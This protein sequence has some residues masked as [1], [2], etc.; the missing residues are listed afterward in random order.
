MTTSPDF[1]GWLP[2]LITTTGTSSTGKL[3]TLSVS[4]ASCAA[5]DAVCS[6]PSDVDGN[7]ITQ[8]TPAAAAAA[9]GVLGLLP[10]AALSGA[11]GVAVS[12]GGVMGNGITVLNAGAAGSV[13]LGA[14]GRAARATRPNGAEFRIGTV[15]TAGN[16]TIATAA[17]RATSPVHVYNI[18][19]YGGVPDADTSYGMLIGSAGL[20]PATDCLPAFNAAKAAIIA[21][22]A[23]G[24]IRI[25]AAPVG[26]G[27]FFSDVLLIDTVFPIE[28]EGEAAFGVTGLPASVCIFAAGTGGIAIGAAASGSIV[29]HLTCC[30]PQANAPSTWHALASIDINKC[31]SPA[32]GTSEVYY[33]GIATVGPYPFT[34]STQPVFPTCWESAI[35]FPVGGEIYVTTIAE[36]PGTVYAAPTLSIPLSINAL[37]TTYGAPWRYRCTVEGVTAE[38]RFAHPYSGPAPKWT[39]GVS[40]AANTIV[41]PTDGAWTGA[42]FRVTTPGTAG[43][44][45]NWALA[46]GPGQTVTSGSVTYTWLATCWPRTAGLTTVDGT[47]SWVLDDTSGQFIDG[48][49]TWNVKPCA[50]AIAFRMSAQAHWE[51]LYVFNWVGD[52]YVIDGSH[53]LG[54]QANCWSAYRPHCTNVMGD[55]WRVAG[56]DCG[57]GH[58]DMLVMSNARG[59]CIREDNDIGNSYTSCLVEDGGSNQKPKWAYYSVNGTA[60]SSFLGCYT[61]GALLS[62]L[63]GTTTLFAKQGRW[64]FTPDSGPLDF[65]NSTRV[66]AYAIISEK[67]GLT[68][69]ANAYAV[70][71]VTVYPSTPNTKRY[72][73]TSTSGSVY[74]SNAGGEP[75][76]NAHVVNGATFTETSNDARS[77]G[78]TI[79]YQVAGAD[80]TTLRLGSQSNPD[81]ILEWSASDDGVNPYTLTNNGR[82]GWYAL[83]FK[84]SGGGAAMQFS[85]SDYA[86]NGNGDTG[87]GGWAAF[88]YGFRWGVS[89]QVQ[90]V[91][92]LGATYPWT[93][94]QGKGVKGDVVVNVYAAKVGDIHASHYYGTSAGV[95]GA[96][97]NY[98]VVMIKDVRNTS[99]LLVETAPKARWDTG[100]SGDST[101][102][103]AVESSRDAKTTTDATANVVVHTYT[104]PN[105]VNIT[106]WFV[107]AQQTAGTGNP[108][109]GTWRITAAYS[110]V[111]GTPTVLDAVTVTAGSA[112]TVSGVTAPAINVNGS[113]L[114]VRVTGVAS[115]TYLWKT[116]R[117]SV[118]S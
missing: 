113:A 73:I 3:Y 65:T 72:V 31:V 19:A 38:G 90:M 51:H 45:P 78:G 74:M 111:S 40:P 16:V 62:R 25:P 29:S 110:I 21:S 93:V 97:T 89:S 69:T 107:T 87:G 60:N 15:D 41:R 5:G 66:A 95:D 105:G 75:N 36:S 56:N 34:G 57:A 28:L 42:C 24:K 54:S 102:L 115:K 61:E 77:A 2:A 116:V 109:F 70:P 88:L 27:W 32:E 44:E 18:A 20:T 99:A 83:L 64:S 68:W 81:F 17:S 118:E 58:G 63:G 92:S 49:V 30:H 26:Q 7:T 80:Q 114:E 85:R 96:A 53:D 48:A 12:D 47:V 37:P 43:A 11:T 33:R 86:G 13:V 112:N 94:I 35:A 9:G 50:A 23:S 4:S 22:G 55:G 59:A 14:S 76:F 1:V 84:N 39:T 52:G 10:K 71:G 46:T 67:Q 103:P 100:L 8:A 108:T 117:K 6:V 106:T 98:G 91:P 104:P 101:P 82:G 79:T